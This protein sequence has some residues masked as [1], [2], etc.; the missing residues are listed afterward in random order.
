MQNRQKKAAPAPPSVLLLSSVGSAELG[1]SQVNEL[2][3]L[4]LFWEPPPDSC[5]CSKCECLCN[6][7]ERNVLVKVDF[8]SHP[9]SQIIWKL[10]NLFPWTLPPALTRSWR[11]RLVP[12]RT[13]KNWWKND[14]GTNIHLSCTNTPCSAGK[15]LKSTN[16]KICKAQNTYFSLKPG[17]DQDM[18]L[19][20]LLHGV[21]KVVILQMRDSHCSFHLELHLCSWTEF[22]K[23]GEGSPGADIQKSAHSI[24]NTSITRPQCPV[25]KIILFLSCRKQHIKPVAFGDST[26]RMLI[27]NLKQAKQNLKLFSIKEASHS[28][29]PRFP[30][31]YKLFS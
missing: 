6:L 10:K 21:W 9:F 25:S 26:L 20:W 11:I 24:S 27:T 8:F 14:I 2:F 19:Q 17:R 30:A 4:F 23:D 22:R 3:L 18:T 1:A 31:H 28:S 13:L 29:H 16:R 7:V 5:L 12:T 15:G